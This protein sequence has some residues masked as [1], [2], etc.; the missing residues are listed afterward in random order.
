M[1]PS[2]SM[3]KNV[4]SIFMKDEVGKETLH[5]AKFLQI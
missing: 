2:M 4:H 5:F 3:L 1:V